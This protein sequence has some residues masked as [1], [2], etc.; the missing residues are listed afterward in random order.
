[1]CFWLEL[2]MCKSAWPNVLIAEPIKEQ[3]ATALLSLENPLKTLGLK[4]WFHTLGSKVDFHA[5]YG[6]LD[7]SEK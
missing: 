7:E 6:A 2:S 1:M 5:F 4:W 3:D